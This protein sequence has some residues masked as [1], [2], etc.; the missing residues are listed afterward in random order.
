METSTSTR[1]AIPAAH[2]HPGGT[3]RPPAL[4]ATLSA[5]LLPAAVLTPD[6]GGRLSSG[7]TVVTASTVALTAL[8][9]A[10]AAA[11]LA[12]KAARA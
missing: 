5:L 12:R 7:D 6:T 9:I 2:R 3:A 11:R 4:I 10:G 8:V 1:E